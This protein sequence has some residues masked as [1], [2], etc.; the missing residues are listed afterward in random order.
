MF[1]QLMAF[2]P[3]TSF[4]RI[5]ARYGGDTRLRTHWLDAT[6]VGE[7]SRQSTRQSIIPEFL[8]SL[9]RRQTLN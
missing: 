9:L 4:R 7:I 5:V 3:W 8:H 1:V 2:V 6:R